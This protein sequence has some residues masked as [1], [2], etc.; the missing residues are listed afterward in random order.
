MSTTYFSW[1]FPAKPEDVL[2]DVNALEDVDALLAQVSEGRLL[3]S[4]SRNN[5]L[6]SNLQNLSAIHGLRH[7]RRL[8]AAFSLVPVAEI[9]SA[10]REIESLLKLAQDAPQ[11][12]AAVFHTPCEATDVSIALAASKEAEVPHLGPSGAEE[13]DSPE[14]LFGWLKSL[15]TLLDHAH[16]RRLCVVHVQPRWQA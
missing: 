2:D 4:A 13:G 3:A 8:G 16:R 7:L 15:R 10:I 14:Y 12:V 6:L 1:A 11:F 5:W 9:P